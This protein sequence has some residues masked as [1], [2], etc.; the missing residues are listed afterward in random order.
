MRRTDTEV[1]QILPVAL[2]ILLV[3]G[4]VMLATYRTSEEAS[5]AMVVVNAA[6]AAAYSA[7]VWTARR[8]NLMAYSNR[9]MLA[10]HI[11]VGHLVAYISW[12]RYVGTAVERVSRYARYLPY[13][14]A[15][16]NYARTAFNRAITAVEMG[17]RPLVA[18]L[19]TLNKLYAAA[20]LDLRREVNPIHL[21]KI[22]RRVAAQYHP[23]FKVNRMDATDQLPS[24]YAA[25]A[26]GLLFSWPMAM[27]GHFDTARPGRDR[28]YFTNLLTRT[29]RHD[30][31]LARWLG[32]RE[33]RWPPRYRDGRRGWSTDI[34]NII[35]FRKQGVTNRA[36]RPSAGGWRSADRLQVSFFEWD[37]FGWGG[38][39]TIASGRANAFELN[40]DYTGVMAYQRLT[41]RN[42]AKYRFRI[43][44]LVTDQR[45]PAL[46][47]GAKA[48]DHN[49][50][51]HA[52]LSVAEVAYKRP[53]R[54]RP[55]SRCPR[56]SDAATLFNP[57]WEA[58]LITTTDL[59]GS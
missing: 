20:Q 9:A 52:H 5:H 23:R 17:A 39:S 42:D 51:R 48:D 1:G 3:A 12:L 33:T 53:A 45:K 14:G 47:R 30:H 59:A 21:N 11:A 22:M 26:K 4:S 16:V 18:G 57:Y 36:P 27:L 13:V 44:A 54:C 56:Q 15:A 37:E 55:A 29:I 6:D 41:E 10:N 49:P 8:M 58:R 7:G 31:N 43:P 34:L 38:W 32:G 50:V 25:G 28:G 40:R 46:S 24:P 35:R 2:A 19:E